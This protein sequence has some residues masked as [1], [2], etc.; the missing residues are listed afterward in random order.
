[1]TGRRS[2]DGEGGSEDP[3]QATQFYETT[4]LVLRWLAPE[5]ADP[6]RRD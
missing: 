4:I 3:R 6:D 2:R 5:L 1:V